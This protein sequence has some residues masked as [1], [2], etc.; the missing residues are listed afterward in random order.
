[1]YKRQ[2]LH[3]DDLAK[4]LD[5]LNRLVDLGNTIVLIE[6]N[7]DI[8]KCADWVIDMGP[9]AGAEGGQ[10]VV[11]G[12]PETIALYADQNPKPDTVRGSAKKSGKQKP[13]SHTGIALAPVLAN[14]PYKVRKSFDPDAVI[15]SPRQEDQVIKELGSTAQM[16]W[17]AD[18]LLYTSPSPR[19]RS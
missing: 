8:V 4:L 5:V 15:E 13:V 14:G 1:M 17:E 19:D 9:E 10:I 16:P 18:C 12:T 7:L 6:H 3:F 11:A 2:G